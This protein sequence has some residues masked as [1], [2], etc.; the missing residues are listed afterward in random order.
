MRPVAIGWLLGGS[1]V[2]TLGVTTCGTSRVRDERPMRHGRVTNV[3][4]AQRT[5]P[6]LTT[7]I[8][9]TQSATDKSGRNY[10][11]RSSRPRHLST[12][13][14]PMAYMKDASSFTQ[15]PFIARDFSPT[16]L[17]PLRGI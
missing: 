4:D 6:L 1:H 7:L 2:P 14:G 16:H 17:P 9:G 13:P 3:L 8:Q 11:A 15:R 5:R 12:K 10:G